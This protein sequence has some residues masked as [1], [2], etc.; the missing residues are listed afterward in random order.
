MPSLIDGVQF[1]H[2]Q[3]Q[4]NPRSLGV[5]RRTEECFRGI[6]ALSDIYFVLAKLD[7]IFGDGLRMVH[8]PHRYRAANGVSVRARGRVTNGLAIAKNGFAPPQLG[9]W[10]VQNESVQA[11]L[12]T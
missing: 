3:S 1:A 12:H 5:I 9:S 8:V 4:Q 11:P 10:I 6:R 7:E 2:N